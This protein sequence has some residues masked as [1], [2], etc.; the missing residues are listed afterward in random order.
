MS[1][2]IT[3][4][5][6][7]ESAPQKTISIDN[8]K[9]DTP[10]RDLID[11][12]KHIHTTK[13][14]DNI[15]SLAEDWKLKK[16]DP[17]SVKYN[18]LTTYERLIDLVLLPINK[19]SRAEYVSIIEDQLA[20]N[21]E[22]LE[23]IINT[24]PGTTISSGV[25]DSQPIPCSKVFL[26][27]IDNCLYSKKLNIHVI[28][29]LL[30]VKYVQYILQLDTF[31]KTDVLNEKYY[32]QYGLAIKGLITER[33]ELN[34][35]CITY[36]KFADEA[37]PL[38]KIIK[39][40][41]KLRETLLKIKN[42][43][44]FDK[45]WLFTNAYKPHAVRCIVLLGIA[46]LFDG[47]TYCD[48]KDDIICKPDPNAYW[49]MTEEVGLKGD[50]I[51]ERLKDCYFIDDSLANL[52]SGLKLNMKK[53]ILID[54]DVNEPYVLDDDKSVNKINVVGSFSDL[55]IAVPEIFE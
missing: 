34:L 16:N 5:A 40:D 10:D 29:H 28:M 8:Y 37:V 48:Y 17:D 33:P 1:P 12:I 45:L 43:G 26:F 25:L 36:N 13:S 3:S 31:E 35:D 15:I 42:S 55:E 44:K 54:H 49:K 4:Q 19:E 27:D 22:A 2:N 23:A 39:P 30:I 47:L 32:K 46:D 52:K 51:E 21:K 50:T 24:S 11:I 9:E 41:L 18:G 53:C 14:F 7:S 38:H 20:R 6:Q